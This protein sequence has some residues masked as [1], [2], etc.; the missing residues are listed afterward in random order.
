MPSSLAIEDVIAILAFITA[1][2]AYGQAVSLVNR[3]NRTAEAPLL[4]KKEE[5]KEKRLEA[6]KANHAATLAL[7][8]KLSRHCTKLEQEI[9]AMQ[10]RRNTL[11]RNVILM[12]LFYVPQVLG[13]VGLRILISGLVVANKKK[14]ESGGDDDA[15][16]Q[17]HPAISPTD[18]IHWS[19]IVMVPH[20]FT[21][22]IAPVPE[23]VNGM[24]QQQIM[25]RAAETGRAYFPEGARSPLF[26]SDLLGSLRSIGLVPWYVLCIV[27]IKILH[28][29]FFS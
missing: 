18:S 2:I 22:W 15:V 20:L 23:M 6:E 24:T 26:G 16:L 17:Q 10:M 9:E 14:R 8:G 5:L 11:K 29:A 28:G 12:V 13:Y 19:E 1:A 3:V 21:S 27:A 4:K 7:H 25:Q